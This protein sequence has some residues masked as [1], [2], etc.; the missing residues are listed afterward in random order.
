VERYGVPIEGET[1]QHRP[2]LVSPYGGTTRDYLT[3]V[4]DL[5]GSQC[6]LVD[7]AGI[8]DAVARA[9]VSAA[10][11]DVAQNA[12]ID[13]AAQRAAAER[14]DTACIRLHCVDASSPVSVHTATEPRS[15]I[16]VF[17]KCDLVP[18]PR[19]RDGDRMRNHIILH[20]SSRTGEG[21]DQLAATILQLLRDGS[22]QFGQVVFATAERCRESLRLAQ[23]ALERAKDAAG[24]EAGHELIAA[25]IRTALGELGKVVGAVYTDDLLDH[26]FSTFCIGK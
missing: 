20:T 16:C 6:E 14:R 5:H 7:T 4:I 8:D 24:I 9:S 19:Q 10:S 18:Q 3:A 2:A 11:P 17:T 12:A 25:E 15:G 1:K 22:W 26:I 23:S 21:V 13:Q